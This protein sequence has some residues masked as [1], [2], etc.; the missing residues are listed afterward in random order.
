MIENKLKR[1]RIDIKDFVLN[2][3]QEK[4]GYQIVIIDLSKISNSIC[5]YFVICHGNSRSQVEAIAESVEET[6]RQNTGERPWHREGWQNAEWIL[7]DFVD[8]VVHVFNQKTRNFYN[9]EGLW[10]DA[11]ITK[12]EE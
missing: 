3:I 6:V 1:D 4:K 7:L 12:I 2:G 10:A 5:D 9:L 11:P 8:V